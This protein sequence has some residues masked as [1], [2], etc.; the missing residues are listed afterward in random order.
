MAMKA[1][2]NE[3]AWK[4]LDEAFQKEYVEKDGT[5]LLDVT[6]VDGLQLANVGKLQTALGSEREALKATK[7]SLKA[8]TDLKTEPAKLKDVLAFHTDFQDGKLS[9]EQETRLKQKE[10]QL[11]EKFETQRAQLETKF[12]K[13]VTDLE[14]SVTKRSNQLKEVLLQGAVSAAVQ[15]FKGNENLLNPHVMQKLR[16]SEGDDGRFITEVLGDDGNPRL[17]TKSSSGMESMTVEE[18]VETLR[19]DPS[20][21]PAFPGSGA[22]GSGAPG[23]GQGGGGTLSNGAVRITASDA[24]DTGLYRAAKEQAEKAGVS[25]EITD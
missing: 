5:Y 7:T 8:F 16:M 2:L 22:Q 25:V 20:F 24:K 1:A 3:E 15:K 14:G 21:A 4:A 19:D 10:T 23:E 17:S 9:D 13:R 18:Y 12:S 6:S 11:A